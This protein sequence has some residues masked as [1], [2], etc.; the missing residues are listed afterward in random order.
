[1][2]ALVSVGRWCFPN[3]YF[4]SDLYL[5]FFV[6]KEQRT[7]LQYHDGSYSVAAVA[8]LI[9]ADD[10]ED[11]LCFICSKNKSKNS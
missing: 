7:A 6:F 11:D 4:C 2:F 10:D 3:Q 9:D 1:M 5:E 8:G